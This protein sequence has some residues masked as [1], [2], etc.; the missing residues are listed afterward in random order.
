MEQLQLSFVRNSDVSWKILEEKCIL[1]NL[2]S[3][4]Y[5]TLNKVGRFLWESLD[6][7]KK[8][9]E[10]C[11]EII[12]HYRIDAETVKNDI[13]DIIQDLLKEG[14]VRKRETSTETN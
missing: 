2:I 10:I 3:G 6:E 5:Y 4:N 11:E 14:L 7:K 9:E 8:L 1:L 13:I 12:D